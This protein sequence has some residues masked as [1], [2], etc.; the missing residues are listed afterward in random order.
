MAIARVHVEVVKSGPFKDAGSPFRKLTPEDR[1]IYEQL[2]NDIHKQFVGD[3]A[4]GR[5]LPEPQVRAVADGRVITGARAKELKLVDEL[6]NLRDAAARAAQLAN[7]KAGEPVLVYPKPR[8]RGLLA[9]L[10][11][12]GVRAAAVELGLELRN[13]LGRSASG[14]ASVEARDPRL[15]P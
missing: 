14:A 10:L 7:A 11:R 9:E 8:D 3:I 15:G 4:K 6:G 12:D 5:K 2:V 1:A 13:M